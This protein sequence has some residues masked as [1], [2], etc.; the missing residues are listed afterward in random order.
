M[1]VCVRRGEGGE[2]SE[3][4]AEEGISENEEG[5]RLRRRAKRSGREWKQEGERDAT[6]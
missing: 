6:L 3:L 2:A 5:G 4:E 1:C